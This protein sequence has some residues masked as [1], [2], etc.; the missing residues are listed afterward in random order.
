M[1]VGTSWGVVGVSLVRDRWGSVV[2]GNHRKKRS[3][4][5]ILFDVK[6]NRWFAEMGDGQ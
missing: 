4:R 6:I 1:L 2:V 5:E 3:K